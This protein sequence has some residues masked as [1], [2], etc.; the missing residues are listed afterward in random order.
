MFNVL[1]NI[2][3]RKAR[4]RLR[5]KEL[6]GHD[7]H[8]VEA[9]NKRSLTLLAKAYEAV[10]VPGFPMPEER[11]PLEKWLTALGSRKD[12]GKLSISIL[13]ENLDG[14]NPTLKAMAVGY[15]YKKHDVGLLA[16]L[17]TAPEFQGKGLGRTLN[18]AN[19]GALIDFAQGNKQPL[20]GIFLECNDPA[21]IKAEDDV[22]DPQKRI[23]MYKKW[24][25]VVLPIDYVQP[26][27]EYGGAKC[28]TLKL[29][30]YPHPVTGQYPSKTAIKGYVSGLYE[31]LAVYAGMAP[32]DNPDYI[33]MM[34]QIDAMPALKAQPPKPPQP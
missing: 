28:D 31:E 15:Y 6:N 23:D 34:Q 13:G 29:M 16:Y 12:P 26:P 10:Y 9:G 14:P 25:A 20:G 33:R 22:M 8:T 30:A 5:I 32:K 17:V 1:K 7:V 4:Q 21:K 27:L 24:G 19:N 2:F 11:E 3:N 18:D